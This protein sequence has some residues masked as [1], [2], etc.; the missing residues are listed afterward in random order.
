VA[1]ELASATSLPHAMTSLSSAD[2]AW[3]T[4][5]FSGSAALMASTCSWMLVAVGE[6][7]G[8]AWRRTKLSNELVYSGT[9]SISSSAM[10]LKYTSRLP[11]GSLRAM[12]KPEFSRACP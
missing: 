12:R 9:R 2:D 3:P 4:V 1:S 7:L 5:R 11:S 10:A 8:S 6:A